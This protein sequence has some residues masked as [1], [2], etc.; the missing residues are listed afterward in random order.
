MDNYNYFKKK[1]RV[2]FTEVIGNYWAQSL[3]MIRNFSVREIGQGSDV[4]ERAPDG[5]AAGR[6]KKAMETGIRFANI[7]EKRLQ[8]F[9]SFAY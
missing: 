6:W 9:I 4:V 2:T 3:E 1:T 5:S 7:S 8:K